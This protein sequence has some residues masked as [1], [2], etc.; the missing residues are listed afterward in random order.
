MRDVSGTI[1]LSPS[2]LSN[3]LHC[4]HRTGLD[5]AVALGAL[6]KPSR[7]NPY[8]TFLQQ[9]GDAHEQRY[10]AS[11]RA[12]GLVVVDLKDKADAAELTTKAMRDGVDVIVQAHLTGGDFAG[13]A[14]VLMRVER[15]S[16]L[17][18]WSYE[19]QD[20]KL[21]RETKGATMVQLSAYSAL[22]ADAQGETPAGFQVITP[23]PEQP[24]QAYRVAD[25]AAYYRK[26]LTSLRDEIARGHEALMAAHYPEPVDACAVCRWESR[27]VGRRRADDHLSFI[28]NASS[29]HRTELTGQGYPTLAK[30]AEMSVPIAF[31][32]SR[33]A[34]E[35]YGRIGDQARVQH[36]QRTEGRPVYERLPIV[37]NAGLC[38]LSAPSAGD[39]FLDLEGARFAREG[40]REY[41][42]GLYANGDV[43]MLVGGGRCGGAHGFRAGDGRHQ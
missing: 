35:T 15:P 31:T 5:L 2:D 1:V 10:V 34:R 41:L 9:L 12:A 25:Y 16:G 32:P 30:V 24:M 40:G 33:G 39:V 26:V 36:Q 29:T 21:A 42:F 27:C 17:G 43:S 14:D 7:V 3:F 8:A 4:R 22:V 37:P 38:R 13:Y 20:T 6:G 11:L 23:D 28:A 19:V 18:A